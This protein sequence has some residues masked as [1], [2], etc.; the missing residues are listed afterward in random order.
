MVSADALGFG[1]YQCVQR[2]DLRDSIQLRYIWVLCGHALFAKGDPSADETMGC[3]RRNVGIPL[4][5]D[6]PSC[7]DDGL[8]VWSDSK[9]PAIPA[10][11]PKIP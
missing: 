10:L 11:R 6:L 3:C 5:H 8:R 7:P 1:I 2:V 9:E 4:Y